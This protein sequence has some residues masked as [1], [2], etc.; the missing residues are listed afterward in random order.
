MTFDPNARLDTSEVEDYRGGGSGFGRGGLV[1]G[2]GTVGIVLALVYV[3]L[4]G[5]INDL[6]GVGGGG[7]SGSVDNGPLASACV[8]GADANTQ[9]QCRIVGD[10]DSVQAFWQSEF[11]ASGQ[12]YT[13]ATTRLFSGSMDTACGPA[14]TD[15]GPFYCPDDGHVYLD[16]G[17][18][19]ELQSQFGAQ[20][21]PFAQ[22]Y[23]VA[24]EYG[25]HVQDLLGVLTSQTG[26]QGAQ[27]ASVRTELQ[28]DCYAGV[29][30]Q[31]AAGTGF[32]EPLTAANIADALDAAA[33]VGDDRIQQEFQGT[34]NPES[35]T[36]GSS[37]QRQHWFTVGYQSGD[38]GKCDTFSG[39]I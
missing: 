19:D 21:G 26:Q 12:T 35:W 18:F 2:G 39:T 11:Q 24:H 29:W 15:V 9:E 17:F 25:H 10:V 22:A 36:H 14:T 8:T 16:L 23:V 1:A 34:V 30:A 7:G 37:A 13:I 31:H 5:N 33:A 28:A 20:G 4:G 6:A 3:L 38:P 32:L 27:G